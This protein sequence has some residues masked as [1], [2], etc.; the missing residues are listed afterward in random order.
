ME[1]YCGTDVPPVLEL[2]HD[3]ETG[4]VGLSVDGTLGAVCDDEFE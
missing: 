4:I 1:L 2:Y 3:G